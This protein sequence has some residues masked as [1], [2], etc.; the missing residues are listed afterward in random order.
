MRSSHLIATLAILVII[1]Y[2]GSVLYG[3]VE[4]YKLNR[5]LGKTISSYEP[6]AQKPLKTQGL[7]AAGIDAAKKA[8]EA[9]AKAAKDA[10]IEEQTKLASEKGAKVFSGPVAQSFSLVAGLIAS[11]VAGAL[12]ISPVTSGAA[13]GASAASILNFQIDDPSVKLKQ[14]KIASLVIN[15][16]LYA[17]VIFGCI[18]FVGCYLYIGDS[19]VRIPTLYEHGR[20]WLGLALGAVVSLTAIK[21]NPPNPGG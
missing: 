2:G 3:A 17:W 1:F 7:D 8:A 14:Q 5:D 6:E 12:A 21:I 16:Y 9:K 4:G 11:I 10:Y 18:C 19:P 15:L 20:L 13:P